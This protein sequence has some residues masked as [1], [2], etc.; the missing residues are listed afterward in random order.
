MQDQYVVTPDRISAVIG[1]VASEGKALAGLDRIAKDRKEARAKIFADWKAQK[2][3]AK[4]FT[5]PKK[6]D[7]EHAI[8]NAFL[9]DLAIYAT[10]IGKGADKQY[11]TA[12]LVAEYKDEALGA[13]HLILGRPKAQPKGAAVTNW[14]AQVGSVL[15]DLKKGY[16]EYLLDLEAP[17]EKQTA[18]KTVKTTEDFLMDLL[19]KA[20]NRTQKADFTVHDAD[21]LKKAIH[22]AALAV[23]GK[24]GQISTG[25]KTKK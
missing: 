15:S 16:A 14:T 21:A 10:P 13:A 2:I 25:D 1:F 24:E 5:K 7:N 17:A 6:G 12:A 8:V 20:Y 23:T 9:Q 3:E 11:L 4:H 18:T 19:Q 22:E